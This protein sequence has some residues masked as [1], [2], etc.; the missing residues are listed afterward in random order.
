MDHYSFSKHD[1]R[2]HSEQKYI[3]ERRCNCKHRRLRSLEKNKIWGL[4]DSSVVKALHSSMRI[5]LPQKT[6]KYWVELEAYL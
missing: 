2:K 4:P 6:M 3:R 5:Q 1:E